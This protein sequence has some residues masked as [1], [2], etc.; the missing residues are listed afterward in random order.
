MSRKPESAARPASLVPGTVYKGRMR[1]TFYCEA[2]SDTGLT[3]LYSIASGARIIVA[4]VIM[5]EDGSITW[6]RLVQT[7]F[8]KEAPHEGFDEAQ[9]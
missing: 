3:L 9:Q 2:V 6:G 8:D 5:F 4:D 1:G 7:V